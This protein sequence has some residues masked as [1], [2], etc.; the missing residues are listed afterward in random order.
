MFFAVRI[1]LYIQD[2]PEIVIA[3]ESSWRGKAGGEKREQHRQ[4]WRE[5][6]ETFKGYSWRLV[7]GRW[8]VA[9]REES[10]SS[11]GIGRSHDRT[12]LQRGIFGQHKNIQRF[13]FED[14][15]RVSIRVNFW[16]VPGPKSRCSVRGSKGHVPNF[17][18]RIA[19]AGATCPASAHVSRKRARRSGHGDERQYK[20]NRFP[21]RALRQDGTTTR[22]YAK[23]GST[24][25]CLKIREK[26]NLRADRIKVSFSSW[27]VWNNSGSGSVEKKEKSR[28]SAISRLVLMIE[29]RI[30][31]SRNPRDDDED[32]SRSTISA[33]NHRAIHPGMSER[34]SRGGGGGITLK[35][36]CDA[37]RGRRGQKGSRWNIGRDSVAIRFWLSSKWRCSEV[38]PVGLMNEPRRKMSF[39]DQTGANIGQTG[40]EPSSACC[41][42]LFL[43]R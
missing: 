41:F 18:H 12:W 2:V 34:G 10:I 33:R 35:I 6:L 36:V 17:A 43:L 24:R 14:D 28:W 38:R 40:S 4:K 16:N 11:L 19:A 8:P 3:I 29:I 5:A 15:K 30:L 39:L 22:L 42:A 1:I 27:R 26:A 20:L 9:Y 32:A 37:F 7:R 13:D 25:G 23:T 31:P 21:S